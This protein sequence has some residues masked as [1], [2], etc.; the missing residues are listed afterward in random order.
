MAAGP[1]SPPPEVVAYAKE[2]ER[3]L[4]QVIALRMR[5]VGVPEAMIGIKG[6]PY[7]DPGA[8]VCTHAIGGSNN[9]IPGRG[10]VGSGPGINVDLAVLDARCT[11]MRAVKS[12]ESAG[13]KDRVDA[14]IAHEYTEVLSGGL[15]PG[16]T[17]HL[18]AIKAAPETELM[19]SERARE[20]LREYRRLEG[21]D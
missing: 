4:D 13:L 15:A 6:M 16:L 8:F 19:I 18:H 21:L 5:T 10:I 12:W 14:V 11:Y 7:E 9:N 20:I 3:Q 1:Y 2:W 17:P